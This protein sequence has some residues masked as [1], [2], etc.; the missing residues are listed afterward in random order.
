MQEMNNE[1]VMHNVYID[2]QQ[3][4]CCYKLEE[5]YVVVVVARHAENLSHHYCLTLLF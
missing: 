5:D 2:A 3:M 1:F 4:W